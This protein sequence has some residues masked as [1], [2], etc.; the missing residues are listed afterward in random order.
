MEQNQ[1]IENLNKELGSL[2][3]QAQAEGEK[4][5]AKTRRRAPKQK[6]VLTKGKRKE[7]VARAKLV[8]GNGIIKINGVSV[9]L[10]KPVETRELILEPVN[11][12]NITKEIASSSNIYVNVKGG[13]A[14]GQAQAA[15]NA[16]AKAI[17]AAANSDIVRKAYMRYDRTPLIDDVRQV[18]PK[19]FLGPKARARF[20]TSYR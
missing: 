19:K 15:R 20:Q 13:G 17:A 10:I 8:K 14:S 7:A 3:P 5:A 12:S 11:F 6:V 16:I 18:E 1:N 9:E 4:K 2:A